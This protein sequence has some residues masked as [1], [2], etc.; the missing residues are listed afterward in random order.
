MERDGG[1]TCIGD[2]AG[3]SRISRFPAFRHLIFTTDGLARVDSRL[4]DSTDGRYLLT[5][6]LTPEL[7]DEKQRAVSSAL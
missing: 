4:L 1:V 6:A 7:L 3:Q 2:P 5:S